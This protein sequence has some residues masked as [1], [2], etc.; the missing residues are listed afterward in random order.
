MESIDAEPYNPQHYFEH[1][2][3]DARVEHCIG[4]ST[5]NLSGLVEGVAVEGVQVC[6]LLDAV[7]GWMNI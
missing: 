3:G 2:H 7:I 4:N 6:L 1:R 5:D